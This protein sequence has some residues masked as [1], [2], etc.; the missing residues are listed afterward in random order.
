MTI[1]SGPFAEHYDLIYRG[2]EYQAESKA[3]TELCAA[4][5]V[6]VPGR[7]LDVAC[8]TGRHSMCL[9]ELGW[10]VTGV[11][12]SE[13]M[14]E[15]ARAVATEEGRDVRFERQDM[16]ELSLGGTFDVI[17]CLFDAI[18]YAISDDGVIQTLSAIRQHLEP[19]GV[20]IFEMWHAPAMLLHHEPV[21]VRRIEDQ[22]GRE[23]VRISETTVD[24]LSSTATVNFTFFVPD[25]DSAYS[26]YEES[27]R[28]RFFSVP[29]MEAL[30]EAA[31]LNA[32]RWY[33]GLIEDG[34]ID[35]D[36][37]HVVGAARCR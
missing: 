32:L 19:E 11:D 33:P 10:T 37:W 3:V 30:L 28:N 26:R 12:A 8:G 5:G 21:R 34:A 35:Q 9:H 2:K 4:H 20:F 15:R 24:A 14:L 31:G 18:G 36:T 6:E 17:V 13:D 23:I 22:G 29:E 27:H 7:L 16:R 1:Y 25:D